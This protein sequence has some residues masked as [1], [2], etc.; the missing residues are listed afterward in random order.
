VKD[1]EKTKSQLITELEELRDKVAKL[2][3]LEAERKQAEEEI[4][5]FKTISDNA[6]YGVAIADLDGNLLYL[7]EY[8]AGV[9]GYNP[10]E[11]IGK[12]LSIF[13]TGEQLEQVVEINKM[14]QE[15]GSFSAL[16]VWHKHK[17]GS[18]FPMLM[19]GVIIE[20]E[21][22][23]PL[24]MTATAID[25]TERKRA[26]EVLQIE[27]AYLEQLI[28]SAQEA[29]VMTDNDGRILR[30]N[31]EFI[32]LFGYTRDKAVGQVLDKL[33]APE[34]FLDEAKSITKRVAKGE[35]V[36]S[37][38][39]RQRYDGQLINVSVLASPIMVDSKQVAV[40]GIY[41]DITERKKAE[42]ELRKA[43]SRYRNLFEGVPVGLYQSTPEGKMIDANLAFVQIIGR[44]NLEALME[45]DIATIYADPEDRRMWQAVMERE[46]IVQDFEMQVRRC[47][48]KVIW[49]RDSARIV[50][51]SKGEV[52]YYEGAV[53]DITERKEAEEE[54]KKAHRELKETTA[55]L[56]H[57]ERM[58][59]LGEL[60]AGVA[61]ELN[62]PLNNIKITSQELLRDIDKNRLDTNTLPQSLGDLVEQVDK[63]AEIITH[64]CIFTRRLEGLH[65]EK[66][67]IN[68][69]VND[70]FIL[71][72]EQ[73]TVHN[74][75]VI[76]D[77]APDL[78]KISGN[79]VSLEQV[80]MNLMLNARNV[81]EEF[82]ESGRSIEIKSF[83]NNK[84]EV[85]VSFKD[86]G[87]GVALNIRDRIFEP[88][89]TTKPPGQGTGLGLSISKKIIEEHG[90][91]IELEV[92]E[93][94]GSTFT[95]I[96]PIIQNAD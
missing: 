31:S 51:D 82:R 90:G 81:V 67:N 79:P 11:L 84:K 49:V 13:H 44:P 54:L 78:P 59:A 25:I 10:N 12:K 5:K 23:K 19:N 40:Y 63:M 86:N 47:D 6:N 2:K 53:E 1:K 36:T 21:K 38:A 88:F 76:K 95:V 87:G 27:K 39:V 46:G 85:A 92:E 42:E 30:V 26:E 41:R 93:S 89:F 65:G 43:E 58:T 71:F 83:K 94:K 8:F 35:K 29:I 57:N 32:R 33:I 9:H 70:I 3:S 60:T 75:D 68:E 77:L 73:L 64:M 66:I 96:L 20:G 80:F 7:N 50:R 28:E 74:I 45:E 55:Q 61:H 37:E 24:F 56:V 14:L 4:K 15:T 34:D 16:E 52:L 91:K 48:G 18:V 62:Q 72:G 17:G 69:P 22:G